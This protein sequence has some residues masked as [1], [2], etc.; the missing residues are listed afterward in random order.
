MAEARKAPEG[1][2]S[3]TVH[4]RDHQKW[5]LVLWRM[6]LSKSD[7]SAEGP[8]EPPFAALQKFG[9]LDSLPSFAA[10]STKVRCREAGQ[11]LQSS[12]SAH[13]Q[14]LDIRSNDQAHHGQIGNLASGAEH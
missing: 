9:R 11:T 1:G 14:R 3:A 12:L 6:G 5:A 2:C 7:P 8:L 10:V 4:A 13:S